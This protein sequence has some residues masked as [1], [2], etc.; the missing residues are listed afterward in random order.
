MISVARP[1]TKATPWQC[2]CEISVYLSVAPPLH[3]S[4]SE[5]WWLSGERGTIIRTVLCCVVYEGCTQW[6]T[7]K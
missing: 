7:Y 3:Y 2:C 6:Y 5:L 1:H 4:S